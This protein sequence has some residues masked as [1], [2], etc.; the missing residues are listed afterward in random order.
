MASTR[1]WFPPLSKP[2]PP[3]HH[4]SL[5]IQCPI[6]ATYG[7][8]PSKE[9]AVDRENLPIRKIPGGGGF[10]LIGPLRER[11][12]YL[13]NQGPDEFFRSRIRE[14]HS[15][16]Y[17]ANLPSGPL[18]AQDMRAVVLLDGKSFP[19]LFDVTKVD[20]KDLFTGTFMPSSELT[21]G[22]RV[23]P[24]LDPSE[25]S[26]A[27]LKKLVFFLLKSRRDRIIPDFRS[28][29]GELFDSLELGISSS[30]RADFGAFNEYAA[31]DFLS[32]SLFGINPRETELGLEGPRI[33]GRWVMFMVGPVLTLDGLPRLLENL[34]TH[35]LRLPLFLTRE[36]SMRLQG[37]FYSASR[38]VLDEAEKIG[39]SREEAYHSLLFITCFN[40]FWGIKI[41]FSNLLKWISRGGVILHTKLA[42]EI[43]SAVR[44]SGGEVTM[45]AIE[46]M[47]LMKSAVYE[48]LRIEPPLPIQYGRAKKDI[49]VESHD[50][51]FEVKRGELMVGYQPLATKDPRIFERPEEFVAMRFVGEGE[52][53][54][55]HVLWSNGPEDGSPN[56]GNKQC[57]GKDFVVLVARLLLVQLF[58]RYD[59]FDIEMVAGPAGV[60]LMLT[61]LKRATF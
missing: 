15:T 57:A 31:F 16:V 44:S 4:R 56:L 27:K 24:Y 45:S 35:T 7:I 32:K 3:S 53:L 43:R 36:D 6:K 19:V 25:L 42:Q 34:T 55:K 1:S 14:Y 9:A 11:L 12:D 37:F 26:H 33:I 58:L 23:L 38:H 59:S 5:C 28:T 8:R 13:Y 30:G 49:V 54:L 41:F 20:K 52:R 40:S 17:R 46:K 2:L 60:S 48:C 51:A 18:V 29:Y 39:I 61:S 47:P 21:G 22:Y 50:S 10:P